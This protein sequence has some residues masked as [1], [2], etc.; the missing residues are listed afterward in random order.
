MTR[1]RKRRRKRRWSRRKLMRKRSFSISLSNRRNSLIR[2]NTTI[3]VGPMSSKGSSTRCSQTLRKTSRTESGCPRKWRHQRHS[4]SV[5]TRN[6][7]S[8]ITKRRREIALRLRN[9]DKKRATDSDITELDML[10]VPRIRVMTLTRKRRN[11][12]RGTDSSKMSQITRNNTWNSSNLIKRIT[13]TL[14]FKTRDIII[15]NLQ[16]EK[17]NFLRIISI[18]KI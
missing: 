15:K 7:R 16:L 1:K 17:K 11:I 10:L 5:K 12:K 9:L 14:L 4:S 2:R 18:S 3:I 6:S 8:L 13:F